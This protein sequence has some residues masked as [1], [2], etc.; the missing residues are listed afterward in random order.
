MWLILKHTLAQIRDFCNLS[1]VVSDYTDSFSPAGPL[2]QRIQHWVYTVYYPH[3]ERSRYCR[4]EHAHV[5]RLAAFYLKLDA[6]KVLST[7]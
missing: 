2:Y 6:D 3:S 7:A 1:T 5:A 4:Q